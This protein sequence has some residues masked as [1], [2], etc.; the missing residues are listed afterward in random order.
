MDAI[1]LSQSIEKLTASLDIKTSTDTN[2]NHWLKSLSKLLCANNAWLK[3]C[4]RQQQYIEQWEYRSQDHD[5]LHTLAISFALVDYDC[6]ISLNFSSF[7]KLSKAKESLLIL[8][9]TLKTCL[10]LG[11]RHHKAYQYQQLHYQSLSAL[12]LGVLELNKFGHVIH[13]NHFANSLIESSLLTIKHNKRLMLGDKLVTSFFKNGSS[14]YFEWEFGQNRFFCHLHQ[15][16]LNK[17]NWNLSEDSY[18][19]IIQP[20]RYSPNPKWLMDVFSLTESQA[21]VASHACL[22]LSAKEI[23]RITNFSANTVYSYLKAIYSK[24]NINN[25]SQLASAIW[26]ALP[27]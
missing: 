16:N 23:E 9:E 17:S 19:L 4:H 11:I 25:Q 24:L 18:L 27:I 8:K 7:E 10:T 2:F 15:Q 20:L 6:Q 22:G 3:N 21:I 1:T 12:N 13:N 14:H 5:T 26:P